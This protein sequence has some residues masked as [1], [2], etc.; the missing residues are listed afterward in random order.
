[1]PCSIGECD[2]L[3]VGGF[4]LLGDERSVEQESYCLEAEHGPLSFSSSCRPQYL[5][6]YQRLRW[7]CSHCDVTKHK[8]RRVHRTF[9][10]SKRSCRLA[11]GRSQ[12]VKGLNLIDFSTPT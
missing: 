4:G 2:H 11:V 5:Y 9:G 12:E 1:M 8:N 3:V 10:S 6:L 7:G